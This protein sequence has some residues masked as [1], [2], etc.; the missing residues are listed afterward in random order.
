[1]TEEK[2]DKPSFDNEPS[3][4]SV[5]IWLLYAEKNFPA[6]DLPIVLFLK[7]YR[8]KILEAVKNKGIIIQASGYRLEVTDE[9]ESLDYDVQVAPEDE[10][11]TEEVIRLALN[12]AGKMVDPDIIFTGSGEISCPETY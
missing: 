9:N 10:R 5:D 3:I 1:M 6:I 12:D 4:V 11:A 8:K 7:E 2:D